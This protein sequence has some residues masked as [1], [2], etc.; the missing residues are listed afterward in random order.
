MPD[1]V[2][3]EFVQDL[4]MVDPSGDDSMA[5]CHEKCQIIS[6]VCYFLRA[7][8]IAAGGLDMLRLESL[9]D[10]D[11]DSRTKMFERNYSA[12]VAM[13]PLTLTK[14]SLSIPGV[15]HFGPPTPLFHSPWALLYLHFLARGGPPTYVWPQGDIVTSLPEPFFEYDSARL[16]KWGADVQ[17][18]PTTTLLISLDDALPSSPVLVQC[19]EREGQTVS[20]VGFPSDEPVVKALETTL[21][22]DRLFGRLEIVSDGEGRQFPIDLTYGVP[23][24]GLALCQRVIDAIEAG[25]LLAP[26]RAESV[27]EATARIGAGLDE[28]VR[29]WSC[30]IGHPVRALC[31]IDGNL[32]WL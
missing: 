31:A 26:A 1:Q 6:R 29:T 23:T 27:H 22:L 7:Q 4:Q 2:V 18:V 8:E 16:Y 3:M 20:E 17:V 13:S 14:T 15:F 25:D 9:L 32:Q 5:S 28:F 24:V 19:F 30:N 21:A 11:D 10:L 12:A